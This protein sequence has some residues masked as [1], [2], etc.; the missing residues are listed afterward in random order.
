M[1][2]GTSRLDDSPDSE[3]GRGAGAQDE[4]E[5]AGA[6]GRLPEALPAS[7]VAAAQE[8]PTEA[9]ILSTLVAQ[10]G[11]EPDK[12]MALSAIRERLTEMNQP[13]LRQVA[14]DVEALRGWLQKF[15]SLVELAGPPG[16]E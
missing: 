6:A 16:E 15:P 5:T 13:R 8:P 10:L 4:G 14:E 11:Q 7:P 1:G 3:N 12:S 2:G 9:V